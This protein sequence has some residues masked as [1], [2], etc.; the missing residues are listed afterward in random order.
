M[1]HS[2]P[3]TPDTIAAPKVI[4]IHGVCP[5]SW[6]ET[7]R[8]VLAPHFAYAAITY[9]DYNCSRGGAIKV[10]VHPLFLLAAIAVAGWT[11]YAGASRWWYAAAS[12]LVVTGASLACRQRHRCADRIKSAISS[13]SMGSYATHVIAHSF[14]TYLT[15]R[16]MGCYDALLDRVVFV[17]CVLP[18]R[19]KWSAV[20]E[21]QPSVEETSGG[22][23][24]PAPDIRNEI[25]SSDLVSWFA[26]ATAWLSRELGSAGRKGFVEGRHRVHTIAGPWQ[27]CTTCPNP[28]AHVHNV[29]LREY[30]HRYLG[31]WPRPRTA[32]LAAVPLG[33]SS[34]GVPRLAER[35][36]PG[37]PRV[38]G[39]E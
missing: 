33:L 21:K 27:T 12:G 16:A 37:H 17:G 10:V 32:P 34:D 31:P 30:G 14:G 28:V 23:L 35:V 26:G 19:F 15:A 4:T 6:Q 38:A 9:S 25:G 11:A 36:Q 5:S 20:F 24:S 8:R 7:A 22:W 29:M 13:E 1:W 2:M 18:R 3:T 39:Q